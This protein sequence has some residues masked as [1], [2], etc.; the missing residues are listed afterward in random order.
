M[1]LRLALSASSMVALLAVCLW[2]PNVD[3][4][5][6]AL[7]MVAVTVG[8]ASVWGRFESM[9]GAIVG[10]AGYMYYF[11]PPRGFGIDAPEH[12]LVALGGFP[13]VSPRRSVNWPRGRSSFWRSGTAY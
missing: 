12:V 1:V 4:A 6:V 8:L 9:A 7:L 11:L 13:G 5:T 10:A 2:L 3:H